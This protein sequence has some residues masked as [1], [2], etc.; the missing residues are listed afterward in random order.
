MVRSLPLLVLL[1]SAAPG[2]ADGPVV[3]AE[4]PAVGDLCRT[5]L[6]L[7]VMGKMK[8][9][10]DGKPD[11]VPV[12]ATAVHTFAERVEV[13]GPGGR[14]ERVVRHYAEAKSAGETGVERSTRALSGDRRVVVAARTPGGTLHY[15]PAGPLSR[16]E[17]DLVAEHFDTL[18][19]A[20]L[21]PPTPVAVGNTWPVPPDVARALLHLDGVVKADL[22]GTLTGLTAGEATFIVSGTAEGV[23]NGGTVKA[24]VTAAGTFDR[25]AKRLA[26]LKWEQ[27]DERGQGPASPAMDLAAT[28]TLTRAAAAEPTELAA[29]RAA[30]PAD[31]KPT[32]VMLLLRYADPAGRYAFVY[33]R[34]WRVV[35]RTADHLTLR[36][37]DGGKFVAQATVTAWKAAPPGKHSSPEEFRATLGKLPGWAPTG[38]TADGEVPTDAGRWLYRVGTT[39][40]QDG[41]PVAQAFYLLAGPHGDQVAV[42]VV[43]RA[44]A[45]DALGARDAAL[46]NGVEFPARK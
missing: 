5:E 42:T 4:A 14:P 18:A 10:R 19:L 44:D 20:G 45:R 34:D 9:D 28:V 26:K 37:V 6:T 16:E 15:S 35:G 41:Q 31:G 8:V 39:G 7:S 33:P 24:K 40:T 3:L 21:L 27:A 22:V 32:P 38:V 11:A 23:E 1:V 30:V 17:L 25:A 46:V 43:C 29:G 36:L 12:T 13:V 2:R